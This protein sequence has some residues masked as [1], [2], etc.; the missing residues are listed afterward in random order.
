M[1]VAFYGSTKYELTVCREVQ[2][3]DEATIQAA[4]SEAPI[5]GQTVTWASGGRLARSADARPVETATARV[6]GWCRRPARPRARRRLVH[7]SLA[8]R[9]A[10]SEDALCA[11]VARTAAL[12]GRAGPLSGDSRRDLAIPGFSN[13]SGA[14]RDTGKYVSELKFKRKN[15]ENGSRGYCCMKNNT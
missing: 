6:A 7:A 4:I 3:T 10:R 12:S 1:P 11:C 14:T 5:S 8:R 13:L 2:E 15:N 9:A